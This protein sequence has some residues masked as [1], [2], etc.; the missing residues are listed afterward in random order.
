M[1]VLP[2]TGTEE[3]GT[4]E[5]EL[6]AALL[7]RAPAGLCVLRGP[8]HVFALANARC[9]QLA[10][11]RE[12]LGRRFQDVLPEW[13]EQGVLT[14]LRQVFRSGLPAMGTEV[15]LGAGFFN[16]V[17]Q[18][19]LDAR[20][21]V[22]GI[23]V[24][25][26]EVTEFVLSRQ[27]MEEALLLM[28]TLFTTA[29]V[30]MC[31]VDRNLRY[32]RINQFLADMNGV[33]I[34]RTLGRTVQEIIPT[35]APAV[36]PLFQRVWETGLPLPDQEVS[37]TLPSRPGELRHWVASYYP[38]K[39]ATGEVTLVG[40]VIRDVSDSKRVEEVQA[41]FVEVGTLLSQS[42]DMASTLK[43]LASLVVAHLSDYC[44]VD[45]LGE[46]GQLQRL[47]VAAREPQLQPLMRRSMP[48]PPRLGGQSPVARILETGESQVVP[49]IT[50]A[51]L[52]AAAQSAEHRA[53]LEAL[54]PRSSIVVPLVAR[55]R[56][57]GVINLAWKQPLVSDVARKL[58]LA[59]GVA[60]RAAV[61]IDNA[62][63]F[64][65]AQEAIRIREDV[66]AVVSHDLRSPL[67]AISLGSSLLLGRE[68]LDE[69][70]LG[71]VRRI[72]SAAE[73]ATRLIRD[74]LDFT[75]ARVS[76][77]PIQLKPLDFHE[78]VRRVV[79]EVRLAW[80][81]RTIEASTSGDGQGEWDEGRLS[82]VV[83]NL[84]GNALQHGPSEEP[85]YVST[86]GEGE[87]VLLE[88]RNA[89]AP[90]PP[91]LRSKLFEPYRRG[92]DAGEGRGS[93]GLGLFITRQIVQGHGG[94]IEV[95][96]TAEEGTLFTVWL[97]RKP[98]PR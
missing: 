11:G 46:D 57:L 38:V 31:V 15:P 10:G 22:E 68:E 87:G 30:G 97:P 79:D 12:L 93:L 96:S 88:V 45:L 37:G 59:R 20:G 55:G 4:F 32:V 54:A 17:C 75:R 7:M 98:A 26:L 82:Q 6:L 41:L 5:P 50:P 23:V 86:R 85:V 72:S 51:W 80:P 16:L 52:D 34:G 1:S 19:E 29:P 49:E 66:V 35:V 84:V 21:E 83:T 62:R 27:W 90:I 8:E 33:P 47:E 9:R 78:L 58:E 3:N 24:H 14:L 63:L 40:T 18:P 77:L 2:P 44:M 76:G 94:T 71:A 73:R 42:L 39:D 48:Y 28:D 36:L 67:S 13:A 53:V 64:E 69:R 74:L 61:A 25:L 60:D 81:G 91:V 56:K 92:S 65:Q 70:T 89:G 43:S 95:R